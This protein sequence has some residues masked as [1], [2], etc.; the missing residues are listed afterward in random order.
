MRTT[1]QERVAHVCHLK[2]AKELWLHCGGPHVICV[3][4]KHDWTPIG[5][6]HARILLRAV[7][8]T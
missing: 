1:S 8:V 2:D 3:S 7:F 4:E 5:A 6:A